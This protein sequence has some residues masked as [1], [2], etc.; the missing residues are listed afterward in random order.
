MKEEAAAG[1][2][3]ELFQ[4]YLEQ[5]KLF[6]AIK[7]YSSSP[8]NDDKLRLFL[9]RNSQTYAF[10]EFV[11]EKVQNY[12]ME[13]FA[14]ILFLLLLLI[15]RI[16]LDNV[17]N[18]LKDP[19]K[20]LCDYS[21]DELER[22]AMAEEEIN[23]ATNIQQKLADVIGMEEVKEEIKELI[24]M[25]KN[26]SK[27]TKAGAKPLKGVLLVGKPGTGKTLL[28]RALAGE[29]T[30]KFIFCNGSDF[31]KMLVGEGEKKLKALFAYAKEKEPVIIFIDEIDS[32]IT[33]RRRSS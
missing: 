18:I 15:Y 16:G 28:A 33:K 29:S 26:H 20:L 7:F 6:K 24:D 4:K 2:K 21:L 23:I 22:K 5:D 10:L 1:N 17:L 12:Y 9:L 3:D 11:K 25:I 8:E 31:D 14:L 13:R 19:T 27:Y 30:V 32:L